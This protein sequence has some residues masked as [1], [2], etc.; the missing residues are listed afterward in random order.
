VR[1][2]YT[3]YHKRLHASAEEFYAGGIL[4]SLRFDA[5]QM[6]TGNETSPETVAESAITSATRNLSL[7]AP[8]ISNFA[9]S[10]E[11]YIKLFLSLV[12]DRRVTGHNL[13]CLFLKLDE[14]A[15]DVGRAVIESHFN[16]KGNRQM[17]VE[18]LELESKAFENWRYAHEKEFLIS[19][20]NSLFMIAK[21]FRDTLNRL[22]PHLLDTLHP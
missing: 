1:S 13:Y 16:S 17:F 3:E 18:L 8:P 11:L 12:D 7:G 21:A 2:S 9:L 19:S 14:A 4:T 6:N 15:P 10:I 5:A 20:P 22:H